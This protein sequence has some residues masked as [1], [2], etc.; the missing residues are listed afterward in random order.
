MSSMSNTKSEFGGMLAA[1]RAEPYALVD[2][3]T[4]RRVPPTFMPGTPSVQPAIT[5]L[6]PNVMGR[7]KS[8]ELWKIVPSMQSAPV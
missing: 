5:W 6:N 4:S 1:A 2:G 3:M 7:P 8:C